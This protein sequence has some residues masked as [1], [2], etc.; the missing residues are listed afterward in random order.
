MLLAAL[1]LCVPSVHANTKLPSIET[2]EILTPVVNDGEKL[3]V[4]VT[5]NEDVGIDYIRILFFS[6]DG[7]Q[8]TF[9]IVYL[10]GE[11][12]GE[13]IL[14]SEALP[15]DKFEQGE[16][17]INLIQVMDEKGRVGNYF[18]Y[19]M[20]HIDFTK[21]NFVLG[22]KPV[23]EPL[24]TP[25]PTPEPTPVETEPKP[26]PAPT[27]TPEPIVK[28]DTPK[29]TP[30]IK[31]VSV[32]NKLYKAA[33]ARSNVKVNQN[34]KYTYKYALHSK[35]VTG[36]NIFMLDSDGQYVPLSFLVDRAA[37]GKSST[38]TIMT[39]ENL[40]KNSTYTLYIKDTFDTK[41]KKYKNYTRTT[42]KTVK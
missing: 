4:K 10:E 20:S 42:I 28:D 36:K 32:N 1:V 35:T 8:S 23:E 33:K 18:D 30:T 11:K 12:K 37:N 27:P 2:L 26:L 25:I 15:F 39:V 3:R 16:W 34:F 5:V 14:E 29:T 22:E 9:P 19:N 24:P 6:P 38:L 7:S 31:P 40:K 21:S 41:N 13:F 17:K